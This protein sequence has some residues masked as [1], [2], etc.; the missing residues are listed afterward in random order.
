MDIFLNITTKLIGNS[1]INLE[2]PSVINENIE[3]YEYLIAAYDSSYSL[4]NS[5]D[6]SLSEKV[7]IFII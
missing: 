1:G 3:S 6:F 2:R 7:G 4:L 5:I